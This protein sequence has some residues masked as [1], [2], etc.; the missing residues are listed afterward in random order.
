MK[1][2]GR[3]GSSNRAQDSGSEQKN[4]S[5]D[6]ENVI[7]SQGVKVEPCSGK[8]SRVTMKL[9]WQVL[10]EM[11]ILKN[12]DC[13]NIHAF[14]NMSGFSLS[15]CIF[16]VWVVLSWTLIDD[17]SVHAANH[18]WDATSKARIKTKHKSPMI[19]TDHLEKWSSSRKMKLKVFFSLKK[20]NWW[21][22]G[23]LG[24]HNHC[25]N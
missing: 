12:G 24:Y 16:D 22:Q 6:P 17:E 7:E 19:E 23:L 18:K 2:L 20:E 14:V 1:S 21:A 10:N 3:I 13:D 25:K 15:F 11:A 5:W 9:L 4:G 8:V